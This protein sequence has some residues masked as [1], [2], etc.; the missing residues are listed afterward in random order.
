MLVVDTILGLLGRLVYA[1]CLTVR[2]VC[3]DLGDR[4]DDEDENELMFGDAKLSA[5][6]QVPSVC[7]RHL[8]RRQLRSLYVEGT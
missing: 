2:V 3:L 4:V 6:R 8:R 1:E 5:E 7:G